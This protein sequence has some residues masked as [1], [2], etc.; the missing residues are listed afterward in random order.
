MS[1]L[2]VHE[3]IDGLPVG[4]TIEL[5]IEHKFFFCNNG[6]RA[7]AATT[8]PYPSSCSVDIAP[9]EC[10]GDDPVTG[11]KIDCFES[12]AEITMQGTGTLAG[13]SR[14]LTV[15]LFTEIATAPRTPG[16]LVQEFEL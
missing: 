4:T 11:G 14:T 10:E 9:G 5:A 1:P 13:F 8:H 16:D 7:G 6:A 2:D 3:I 15:P 12:E